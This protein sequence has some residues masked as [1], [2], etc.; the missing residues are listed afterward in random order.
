MNARANSKRAAELLQ[1]AARR[2]KFSRTPL[3]KWTISVVTLAIVLIGWELFAK[4]LPRALL[5]PPSE[6]FVAAYQQ[7]VVD[8]SAWGPLLNSTGILSAG[9]GIALALGIPLGIA[10][11]RWK[12]VAYALDPYVTFLY[13]IPN[14]SLVP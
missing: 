6:I 11:G 1:S 4:D 8:G 12:K 7:L 5:A 13:S 3:G 9:L 14:V 10:M 2:N